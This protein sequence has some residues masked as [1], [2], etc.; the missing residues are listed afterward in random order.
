[1]RKIAAPVLSLAFLILFATAWRP[2]RVFGSDCPRRCKVIEFADRQYVEGLS[3]I[4]ESFKEAAKTE[5]FSFVYWDDYEYLISVEFHVFEGGINRP[6]F[7]TDEHGRRRVV[8][9]GPFRS[10]LLLGL[11]FVAGKA[12]DKGPGFGDFGHSFNH[13]VESW[14]SWSET[15]DPLSHK[16]AILSQIQATPP[17]HEVAWDYERM[18]VTIEMEPEKECAEYDEEVRIDMKSSR[19]R[20]GREAKPFYGGACENRFVFTTEY[21]EIELSEENKI[22]EKEW[23]ASSYHRY[24]T[25]KAP[26]SEECGDCDEDTITVY[27]SCD[28]LDPDVYPYSRTRKNEKIYELKIDIGCDWEGTISSTFKLSSSGDESLLTAMMPKSKYLG[29]TIWK[30]DVVFKLD[31][32]N[33]RVRIYELKSARF[34]FLD[35]LESEVVM[36]GEAGKIQM[37]GKDEAE[38]SGRLLSRSECGLEL[39]IDLKKKTYKIEGKLHVENITVTA[40]GRLVVDV[41]PIQHDKKEKDEGVTE[42]E[43][44]I[45]IE[46]KFSGES[47]D[48]LEGSI[49]EVKE[50]PPEFVEFTEALAGKASGKIRWRLEIKGKH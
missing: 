6:R 4:I 12:Q 40:D 8:E 43:E 26:S 20:K 28:V 24:Y 36:Q 27:N 38:A 13:F 49:D 35:Q 18:P 9:K 11:W 50:L 17:L 44:E 19:D 30:L 31:R 32:A 1:M 46:S 25:Y 2:A 47:P 7:E 5:Y 45:L 22:R 33:E 39:I 48:E 34:D 42:Y 3:S 14:D 16:A 15:T 37:T 29:T 10:H 41:G 21:G 23:G